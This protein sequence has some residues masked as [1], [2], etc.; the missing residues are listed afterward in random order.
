MRMKVRFSATIAFLLGCFFWSSLLP[1]PVQAV[2]GII[3]PFWNVA[4]TVV[5]NMTVDNDGKASITVSLKA[6][7]SECDEIKATVKLQQNSGQGWGTLATFSGSSQGSLFTLS[8]TYY[9][10]RGAEYRIVSVFSLY[11]NS[12]LVETVEAKPYYYGRYE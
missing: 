8:K 6:N 12:V 3:T 11:K 2:G 10:G 5:Q 7:S 9:I 1:A 4:Q